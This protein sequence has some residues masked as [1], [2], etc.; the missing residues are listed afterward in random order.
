MRECCDVKERE[1]KGEVEEGDKRLAVQVVELL[2]KV[3]ELEKR[4]STHC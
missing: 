4:E 3:R 1:E 2:S